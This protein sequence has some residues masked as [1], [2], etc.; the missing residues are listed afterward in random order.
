LVAA[1]GVL[2]VASVGTALAALLFLVDLARAQSMVV[3]LERAERQTAA[4][5]STCSADWE[6]C[7]RPYVR[8]VWQ[9]AAML[10]LTGLGALVLAAS[11]VTVMIAANLF[12]GE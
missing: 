9:D 11:A 5:P 12:R 6:G 1:A 8:A 2:A 4:A 3:T 10:A 7:R